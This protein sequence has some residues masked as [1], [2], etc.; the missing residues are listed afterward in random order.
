MKKKLI[1]EPKV[2][3]LSPINCRYCGSP[4]TDAQRKTREYCDGTC[5]KGRYDG[6]QEWLFEEENANAK[7]IKQNAKIL[8]QIYENGAVQNKLTNLQMVGFRRDKAYVPYINKR[9][10]EVYKFGRVYL[11]LQEG[12]NVLLSLNKDGV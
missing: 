12:D 11:I 5:R 8:L 7:L 10:Q 4:I 1:R 2:K 6:K 3:Y 9:N